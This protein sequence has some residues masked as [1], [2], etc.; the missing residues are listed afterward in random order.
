MLV[1]ASAGNEGGPVDSPAN[2]PGVA[3]IAGLR[4]AGTKVGYSSVGP[5]IALG[6]PAGNCVNLS[7]PCLMPIET[8]TNDGTTA[9]GGNTYAGVLGTSFSAPIVSAIGG[10][11]LAVDGNLRYDQLIARL[12]EGAIAFPVSS[13]PTVPTCHVPTGPSD[14]QPAECNCTTTTCGAGMAN[15]L[16]AVNAALRPIAAVQRPS[17]VAPTQNVTLDASGSGAACGRVIAA[18]AW[19]VVSGSAAIVSGD[20][21]ATVVISHSTDTSTARLVVTDDA[22]LT[23]TVDVLVGSTFTTSAAPANAGTSACLAAV[24]APTPPVTV[25]VSPPSATVAPGGTQPFTATLT[26]TASTDVI[27][28]VNAVPGGNATVGTIAADGTY[29]APANVPAQTTVTV[30]ALWADD[31]TKFAAAQVTLTASPQ[32]AAAGGGGGGGGGAGLDLLAL[33]AVA[34]AGRR[35]L[36]GGRSRR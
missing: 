19:S 35:L 30:T 21:A 15:A 4:H 18:Y 27:W 25:T 23:D 33:V 12:Q 9:P 28:Q 6:A 8:A 3:G 22:G 1:V 17:S 32:P 13:D 36:G 5:E 7:G 34:A 29:T 24:A 14:L 11:M 20:T 16:G 2:C 26:N 31:T 10:L